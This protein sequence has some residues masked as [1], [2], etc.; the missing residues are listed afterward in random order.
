MIELATRVKFEASDIVRILTL[1]DRDILYKLDVDHHEARYL[2]EVRME[3][4]FHEDLAML[5]WTKIT[6]KFTSKKF[7]NVFKHLMHRSSMFRAHHWYKKLLLEQHEDLISS[8]SQTKFSQINLIAPAQKEGNCFAV[9][10]SFQILDWILATQIASN[11]VD[12]GKLDDRHKLQLSLYIFPKQKSIIHMISEKALQ[13]DQNP[14]ATTIRQ[15]CEAAQGLIY[16]EVTGQLDPT[17]FNVPII[18]N[19]DNKL[20]LKLMHE[21]DL[22]ALSDTL[23]CYISFRSLIHSQDAVER[24]LS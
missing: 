2:T 20:P 4:Q 22:R 14:S 21:L 5:H 12:I 1:D 19:L 6:H 3:N 10:Y 11:E 8:N 13:D 9:Q 15:I 23:L 16:Q 18:P 24:I 17:L 7:D